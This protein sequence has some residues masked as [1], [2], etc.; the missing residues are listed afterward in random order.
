MEYTEQDVE[1]ALAFAKEA[2]KGQLY[3]T[4]D[5]FE[6]HI[7][8]VWYQL[9]I[10]GASYLEQIVGALHD[11]YEDTGVTRER[12]IG[13][14]GITVDNYVFQLTRDK[15]ETYFEYVRRVKGVELCKKV[16]LEDAT[17]N[18]HASLLC[19]NEK[20]QGKYSRAMLILLGYD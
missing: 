2:H 20:W 9:L 16:K 18:Y 19:E 6:S 11:I 1:R 12:L 13:E 15:G 10:H 17:C 8:D 7:K 4:K 14:F 3:G 5:Y